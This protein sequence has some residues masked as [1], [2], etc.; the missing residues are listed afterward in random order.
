MAFRSSNNNHWMFGG[1]PK[2]LGWIVVA[3]YPAT[4]EVVD[5]RLGLTG[6]VAGASNCDLPRPIGRRRNPEMLAARG[7]SDTGVLLWA[8]N[9]DEPIHCRGLVSSR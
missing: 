3:C 1:R 8:T 4:D 5:V 9:V 7:Q 6:A 2:C